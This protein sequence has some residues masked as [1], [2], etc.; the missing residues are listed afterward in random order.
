MGSEM[1]IRDSII[2]IPE[3]PLD[4]DEVCR[5]IEER[6]RRGEHYTLI[7]VAE[8]V[9]IPT[10]GE[11]AVAEA[12]KDEYGHVRLGGIAKFLEAEL[13]RR[14]GKEVRSTILGYVQR[15]GSPVAF[16]R[17]LGIRLG[18][19]AV[20]LVKEKKFGYAVVLRGTEIVPVKL[21][22]VVGQLRKVPEEF[23]E[24]LNVFRG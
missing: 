16:D 8:G 7:A 3:K 1:C 17:V 13:K 18:F 4:L 15:G 2:L 20:D 24:Y 5:I 10:T 9:K 12:E 21:D 19:K 11:L 6:E 22:E 23:F 14:L